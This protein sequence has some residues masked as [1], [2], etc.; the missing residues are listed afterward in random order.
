VVTWTPTE[1][2]T[3]VSLAQQGE[4]QTEH[5]VDGLILINQAVC[6]EVTD[7]VEVECIFNVMEFLNCCQNG[8]KC[9]DVLCNCIEKAILPWNK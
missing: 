9:I 7:D 2:I 3:P 6:W 1:M 4:M 5:E 8:D